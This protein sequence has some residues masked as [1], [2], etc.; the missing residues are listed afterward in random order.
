MTYRGRTL[1]G[2]LLLAATVVPAAAAQAQEPAP[3][4]F[5]CRAS[6]IKAPILGEPFI[7]N[8]QYTPCR[9]SHKALLSG[10]GI[11]SD[12][13]NE[14]TVRASVL[15]ATTEEDPVA[16]ETGEVVRGGAASASVAHA[17][18]NAFNLIKLNVFGISSTAGRK[19]LPN[20]SSDP[21]IGGSSAIAHITLNGRPLPVSIPLRIPLLIGTLYTNYAQKS[22]G[23]VLT[24]AVWLDLAGDRNDVILGEARGRADGVDCTPEPVTEPAP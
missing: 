23:E 22:N 2:A 5:S 11:G 14:L 3:G 21:D 10:V 17:Y 6:A 18:V 20:G 19:C 8:D 16:S 4:T 1:L 15:T 9:D 13:A 24:R 12:K 7:A